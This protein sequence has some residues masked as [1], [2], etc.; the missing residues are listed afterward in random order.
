LEQWD[1]AIDP[2]A[3]THVFLEREV[4]CPAHA[5]LAHHDG[6]AAVRSENIRKNMAHA[7]IASVKN[8]VDTQQIKWSFTDKRVL[9]IH[10]AGQL[11]TPQ[12]A[13][14]SDACAIQFGPNLVTIG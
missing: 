11:T 10:T 7:I 13:T 2:E 9:V 6:Y 12:K 1:D 8:G 4:A 5:H 3:R 14:A